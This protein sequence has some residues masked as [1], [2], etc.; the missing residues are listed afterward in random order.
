MYTVAE[1]DDTT[2]GIA[3]FSFNSTLVADTVV[4]LTF[5]LDEDI[6][7]KPGSLLLSLMRLAIGD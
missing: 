1:M 4:G 3:T 7:G 5:E 6:G 2:F